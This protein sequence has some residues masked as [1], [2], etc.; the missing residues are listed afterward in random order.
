MVIL[1]SLAVWCHSFRV[2]AAVGFKAWP[3]G[4]SDKAYHSIPTFDNREHCTTPPRGTSE[5]WTHCVGYMQYW[6]EPKQVEAGVVMAL[7]WRWKF[8]AQYA[9]LGTERVCVR[10]KVFNWT[11]ISVLRAF[12]GRPT[13]TSYTHIMHTT[14]TPTVSLI[15]RFDASKS[16]WIRVSP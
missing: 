13:T 10:W 3:T 11:P 15:E 1:L 7:G 4:L 2:L 12:V 14:T 5:I 8:P 9:S 16:R 6:A